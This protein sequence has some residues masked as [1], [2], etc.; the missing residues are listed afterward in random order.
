VILCFFFLYGRVLVGQTTTVIIVESNPFLPQLSHT[1]TC[2]PTPRVR[3]GACRGSSEH[4]STR[5]G[6]VHRTCSYT[7]LG[8]GQVGKVVPLCSSECDCDPRG[9]PSAH[10]RPARPVPR[11]DRTGPTSAWF[12]WWWMVL[13][14]AAP[15]SSTPIDVTAYVAFSYSDCVW[16]VWAN[17]QAGVL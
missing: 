10:G 7:R 14:N 5:R 17:T 2:A 1:H 9:L 4:S 12:E 13:P 11:P 6:H 8:C 15:R 3:L 16:L